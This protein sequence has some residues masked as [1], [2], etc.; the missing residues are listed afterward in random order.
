MYLTSTTWQ[1]RLKEETKVTDSSYHPFRLQNQYADGKTS[2]TTTS[3]GIMNL[4][5]EDLSF[6]IRLGCFVGRIYINLLLTLKCGLN[7]FNRITRQTVQR[8]TDLSTL[9]P[10]MQGW[11]DALTALQKERK[12][13]D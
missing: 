8:A 11:K 13:E 3:S 5:A 9:R 12:K 4:T 6:R 1:R 10:G 7:P 2:C